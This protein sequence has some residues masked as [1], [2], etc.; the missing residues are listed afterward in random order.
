MSVSD[1]QQTM[2]TSL[3]AAIDARDTA[4][5]LQHLSE[6]ARFRFGSAPAADGKEQIGEAV[7]GFFSTIASLRH[8]VSLSIA[9]DSVLICEGEVTYTRHNGSTIT[10]PFVDVFN[11]DA[12]QITSYKIYM[13]SGPLYA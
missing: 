2:L 8:D 7:N 13:D 6:D 5:F 3:F 11:L 1:S 10:L 4:A 12:D 9:E